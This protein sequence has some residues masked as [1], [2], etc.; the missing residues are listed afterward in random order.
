MIS[1]D[2]SIKLSCGFAVI[3]VFSAFNESL[4]AGGSPGLQSEPAQVA[5]LFIYPICLVL[6]NFQEIVQNL[7]KMKLNVLVD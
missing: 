4:S 2:D 3:L 5:C 1:D 6:I 7:Y